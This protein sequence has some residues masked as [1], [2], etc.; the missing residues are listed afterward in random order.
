MRAIDSASDPY[1]R[2]PYLTNWNGTPQAQ[3]RS[4]LRGIDVHNWGWEQWT[5]VGLG[6]YL[7]WATLR[8]R[9]N[10]EDDDD[11]FVTWSPEDDISPP[12]LLADE[13]ATA[14]RVKV[15]TA[16][17]L[18]SV[19]IEP[20]APSK[21]LRAGGRVW[22]VALSEDGKALVHE[23]RPGPR[24]LP[25]VARERG[26]G[27]QEI[28]AFSPQAVTLDAG[29]DGHVTLPGGTYFAS[30]AG[31]HLTNTVNLDGGKAPTPRGRRKSS[32]ARTVRQPKS[33]CSP[34]AK[35]P[36]FWKP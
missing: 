22:Q 3:S 32:T 25:S 1:V 17:D 35:K 26:P 11:G 27:A 8:P 7:L 20:G 16:A 5:L 12:D 34:R 13:M 24:D 4:Y 36:G 28:T 15:P 30:P 21:M 10:P 14:I 2:D 6:A 23:L 19:G 29:A 9:E 18:L 31:I 33:R